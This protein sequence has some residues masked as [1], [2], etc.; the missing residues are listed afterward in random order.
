MSYFLVIAIDNLVEHY[1]FN[2]GWTRIHTD[3]K[4]NECRWCNSLFVSIRVHRCSSVVKLFCAVIYFPRLEPFSSSP[5][6]GI[7]SFDSMFL[8]LVFAW[9]SLT[10][11]I[12]R[13]V[14]MAPGRG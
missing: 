6:N 12:T 13:W 2:H 8:D 11:F 3:E 10:W 9:R 7:R 1:G 4:A 5:K 14:Q